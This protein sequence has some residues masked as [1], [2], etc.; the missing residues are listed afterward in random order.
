MGQEYR[1]A[2]IRVHKLGRS[3]RTRDVR[4][5]LDHRGPYE[6]KVHNLTLSNSLRAI[7]ER[8]FF[9]SNGGRFCR[10]PLPK[11][12]LIE[13]RLQKFRRLVVRAMPT[14]SRISRDQFVGLYTGRRK[15]VMER[16]V[17]SLGR[18]PL[19]PKD[20]FISAF[21]KAE[22]VDVTT[23]VDPTPRIIQPR[24]PR[25]NVEVGRYLKHI[26][27]RLYRAI[28]EIFGETTVS[29]GL[30]AGQVGNLIASKWGRYRRPVAVGLDASRF[31]QHCSM[32]ILKWEHSVYN[33][34]YHDKELQQL[35]RWQLRNRGWVRCRD[36]T[37]KYVTEGCRMSGDMNT[38]LGN[39]L[40]MCAMVH[41]YLGHHGLTASLINNGDDCVLFM[42]QD[43][44][45]KM[46]GLPRYFE[47]MGFTMVVEDPVYV[48]E[49]VVFCQA[50]PVQVA[51]GYVMC[52]QWNALSKDL[53]ALKSLRT[54]AEWEAHRLAVAEC[55]LALAGDLPVFGAMYAMLGRNC[56][57][58]RRNLLESGMYY[59]SLGM[60][61]GR[62]PVMDLT[63]VSFYKAF[64]VTPDRQRSLERFYDAQ[65]PTY[66][67]RRLGISVATLPL[68]YNH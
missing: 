9:V 2:S 66:L 27:H 19:M 44:F 42:E 12:G 37:I 13:R 18:R 30:N 29:K 1:Q 63:R 24:S 10:P 26:E 15:L 49:E 64:K 56:E 51:S 17:D 58:S 4:W 5:L 50:Q 33:A 62:R 31:D 61:G 55:G 53:V 46:A 32:E 60:T 47:D 40:V 39:C 7:M 16:A 65:A 68:L 21:V 35:L 23:K 25:Y 3:G 8:V 36:G 52:R 11:R 59:L 54:A 57:S 48:L 45:A 43:D 34:L 14:V 67:P 41:A 20:A 38:A 28:A 22:K 6:Y